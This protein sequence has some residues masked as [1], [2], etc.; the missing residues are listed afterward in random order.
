MLSNQIQSQE[1]NYL[2]LNAIFRN[3]NRGQRIVDMAGI[4]CI[5]WLSYDSYITLSSFCILVFKRQLGLCSNEKLQKRFLIGFIRNSI[6]VFFILLHTSLVS[7]TIIEIRMAMRY[8]RN[9]HMRHEWHDSQAEQKEQKISDKRTRPGDNRQTFQNG[10]TVHPRVTSAVFRGIPNGFWQ[11][12]AHHDF[13][14]KDKRQQEKVAC[15]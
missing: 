12:A 11:D 3:G 13:D 9:Q 4:G 7:A 1:Q 14:V 8:A 6:N 2:V 5:E 10:A 15:S